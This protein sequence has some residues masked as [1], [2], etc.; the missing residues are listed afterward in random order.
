MYWF[1][2]DDPQERVEHALSVARMLTSLGL[3]V[4]MVGL[5]AIGMTALLGFLGVLGWEEAGIAAFGILAA[6]VLSGV[7]AYGSGTNV[8]LS[9]VRLQETLR[10]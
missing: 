5:L 3:V 1:P 8:G 10:K 6:T 7:A 9:A 4:A 2:P